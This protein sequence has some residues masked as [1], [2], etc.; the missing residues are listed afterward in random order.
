MLLL[1]LSIALL[2][3]GLL[4]DLI[5]IIMEI[6]IELVSVALTV[7][8]IT[9]ELLWALF[10]I[11]MGCIVFGTMYIGSLV[12]PI[13]TKAKEKVNTWFRGRKNIAKIK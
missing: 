8:T 7:I 12:M 3:T 11:F 9:I 1:F 4:T 5:G 2:A 6:F 10:A 13:F